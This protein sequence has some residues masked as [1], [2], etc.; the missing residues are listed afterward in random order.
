MRH[1]CRLVRARHRAPS[2]LT[3]ALSAIA[4]FTLLLLVGC[5]G[6]DSSAPTEV[7]GENTGTIV[8]ETEPDSLQVPW[9][10]RSMSTWELV[11]GNGDAVLTDKPTGDYR[12]TWDWIVGWIVPLS[13][14]TYGALEAGDTLVFTA[15]YSY[16]EP[17]GLMAP[18]M[19]AVPGGDFTMGDGVAY[20]GLDQHRVTLTHDFYLGQHEVTNQE[21][22]EALQWA[23]DRGFV[24]ATT[25]SVTDNLSSA[26][27]LLDL[28]GMFCEISYANGHFSCVRPDRPV[29]EVSWYGAA[30]YCDWLSLASVLPPT[31][32]PFGGHDV[33][34]PYWAEG[35]RLPTDAEWEYA[36]QYDDERIYPWGDAP[37]N[38]ALA[39]SDNCV[40]STTPV[41]SYPD[42]PASLGLSDMAGNVWEW[43]HDS[44]DE[45]LGTAD[46]VDPVTPP[47]GAFAGWDRVIRGNGHGGNGTGL[48]DN[49]RCACRRSEH[50][51]SYD[52]H[53]CTG[54]RI[55]RTVDP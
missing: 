53:W 20:G 15:T 5:S 48:L 42:A 32:C 11:S 36:A 25:T 13:E 2:G 4:L 55:A 14:A 31:Y 38:C 24:T 23:Y 33:E 39:N 34:R 35:Y 28:D 17:G 50:P 27:E 40:G 19:V 1:R 6:G 47:C 10:L 37:H 49:V 22:A 12:V 44:Y 52:D 51:G 45:F 3:L 9:T 7:E 29:R 21:Y 54:F 26:S 43:C 18:P 41:G 30:R 46:V 16:C 8:I